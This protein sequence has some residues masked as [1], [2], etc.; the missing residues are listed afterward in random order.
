MNEFE[1][2]EMTLVAEHDSG[3][4][5]W[6]CPECNRRFIMTWTPNY[7]KVVLEPGDEYATHSGSIGGLHI[8]SADVVETVDHILSDEM[9]AALDELDLDSLF[10]AAD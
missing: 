1:R 9:R 5:E 10:D 7:H 4:Q 3:A 8:G 2:H 6:Y